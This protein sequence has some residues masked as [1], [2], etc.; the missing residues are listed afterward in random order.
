MKELNFEVVKCSEKYWEFVRNL[1]NNIEVLDG[2]INKN[3]ITK[4]QQAEYMKKNSKYFRIGLI[5]GEPAGYFG[6]IDKDIRICTHPEFQKNG[7][8]KFM[9]DELQKIWPD[10]FAKIKIEN[11]ASIK[12]FESAGYEPVFLVMKQKK[13]LK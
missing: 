11:N 13:K 2:F 8:G 7:L 10:S 1:R 9:L 5:N 4:N 6:V 12:L 3:H